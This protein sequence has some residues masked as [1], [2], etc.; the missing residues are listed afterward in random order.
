M[1][2]LIKLIP[3]MAQTTETAAAR[4]LQASEFGTDVSGQFFASAPK[5]LTGSM[6]PMRHPHFHDRTNQEATWQAVVRVSGVDYSSAT[7]L[8]SVS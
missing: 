5:K 1:L 3:G 7:S 2:P 4:Y 8:S 6:E